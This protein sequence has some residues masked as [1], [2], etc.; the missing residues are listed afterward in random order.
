MGKEVVPKK[1][2]FIEGK[3]A[4]GSAL[5]LK[6]DRF[7]FIIGRQK[8]CN[9]A[10][11][12]PAVSRQHA[13]I[14]LDG[15]NLMLHDLKSTNGT[16]VNSQKVIEN[17][18]L[19]DDDIIA[20]ADQ[21]FRVFSSEPQGGEFVQTT[22]HIAAPLKQRSFAEKYKLSKREEEILFELLQGK[23]TKD[24]A[25]KLFISEGTAKNHILNIFAKTDVHSRYK[26]LTLYNK[27]LPGKVKK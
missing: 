10:I 2:W 1:V 22:D 9:L 5:L 12:S 6:I 13:V 18:L 17:V 27:Y 3:L 23:S 20:F 4:D 19:R 11:S 16:F 21:E 26:L 7:P 25:K 15:E 14:F 24:I 8:K